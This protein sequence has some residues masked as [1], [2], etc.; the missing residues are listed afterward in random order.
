MRPNILF[1]M[2]DQLRAD[3]LGCYGAE[4]ARTPHLDA[5]A[6]ESTLFERCLAPT[7]ICVPSR[8]SML[9]GQSSLE[10][11]IL[12]NDQWL[13]LDRRACGIHSWP[14]LLSEAGYATYAVGKMH[15]TP[16][17]ASEGFQT[18]MIAEDKRHVSLKDDYGDHLA[19]IGA[20]KLHGREMQGY[21]ENS[22]A[23]ISPLAPEDH[24]DAWCAEQAIELIRHH[25]PQRPFA[26][27]VGFPSPHCPYDPPAEMAALFDADDMPP[28]VPA[29]PESD[30]LRPWF[31]QN[32][33]RPWADID[34]SELPPE[35]VAKVRAHYS[36]LIHM[37]DI[38]VGRILEALRDTG[39]IDDTI[40]VF[41]SDHGDFVGDYGMVCKNYFMD[42]SIRVP[43]ILRVPGQGAEVRGDTVALPDLYP[44]LLEAAGIVPRDG[45]IYRS[46]LQ[47][48]PAEP[49]IICGATHRGAMVERDGMKLARYI[50]GPVT[51]HDTRRDPKEQRNLHGLLG[52][53]QTETELDLALTRWM[54]DQSLAAHADKRIIPDVG[55]E[56][57]AGRGW[58]RPY[59]VPR[60]VAELNA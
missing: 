10:S 53:Q 6:A 52:Y 25:E 42:G 20:R 60:R 33:L 31:V 16:W 41:A 40:I 51:L 48:A 34:Y 15:F 4:F 26:M 57:A 35:K 58:D 17:D 38:A 56:A 18:R 8:A 44:T 9:T 5:L 11:G 30:A 32:M 46:L 14:E 50:D 54:I 36:A 7:P 21:V 2:P 22:G 49:R 59:P 55:S 1:L 23:C 19:R 45:L 3:F 39:R 47:P 37:L 27:M 28:A 12:A 29:T 43:M 24:V 13:R